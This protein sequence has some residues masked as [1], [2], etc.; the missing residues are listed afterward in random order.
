MSAQRHDPDHGTRAKY[1][2]GCRCDLCRRANADAKTAQ[3]RAR[4]VRTVAEAAADRA[5]WANA[6]ATPECRRRQAVGSLC[7]RC[8][9][10]TER[11]GDPSVGWFDLS[12]TA[13]IEAS[14][15]VDP[16]SGCWL[17]TKATNH[18]GY[19]VTWDGKR[20]VVAHRFSYEAFVGPI[21][22]GLHLDH[23]CVTPACVNPAH[24]EPV[25]QAENNRREGERRRAS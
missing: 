25:T 17:W 21:P 14:V 2:H 8:A 23:L 11:H 19:G 22:D 5:N 15:N 9:R 13:R 7:R 3:A 12:A 20:T 6:C 4:G 1:R 24:L 16:V 18:G 10:R